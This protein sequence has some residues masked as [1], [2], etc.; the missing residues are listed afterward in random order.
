MDS[1]KLERV[2]GLQ[3]EICRQILIDEGGNQFDMPHSG[4]RQRQKNNEDPCDRI[5]P[6]QVF[7]DPKAAYSGLLKHF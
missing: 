3:H 5:V 6:E 7:R 4:V 1:N 2:E